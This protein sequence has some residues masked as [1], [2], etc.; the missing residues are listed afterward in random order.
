MEQDDPQEC[1]SHLPRALTVTSEHW[2]LCFSHAQQGISWVLQINT[3]GGFRA[4]TLSLAG[5]SPVK[6]ERVTNS[7]RTILFMLLSCLHVSRPI[8]SSSDTSQS[9][10]LPTDEVVFRQWL[11][12]ENKRTQ[13]TAPWWIHCIFP[14]HVP[15]NGTLRMWRRRLPHQTG[16]F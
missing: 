3:F 12:V 8:L 6:G 2:E 16:A 14:V 15:S 7:M 10:F 11:T 1:G 4:Q 5:Q 13:I 9:P